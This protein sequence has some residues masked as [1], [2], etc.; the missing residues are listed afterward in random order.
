MIGPRY[1]LLCLTLTACG[2]GDA[3]ADGGAA[4]AYDLAGPQHPVGV[5]TLDLKDESREG[6][7]RLPT[8]VW[9]PTAAAGGSSEA[10]VEGAPISYRD[11]PPL[12]R[13]APYPVVIFSHGDR[14]VPNQ[15][16]FL[17]VA[18]A[19]RGYVVAAVTHTGNTTLNNSGRDAA[20]DN[21]PKDVS[22]ALTQLLE[23]AGEAAALRGLTD[24]A[25]VGLSGHSFGAWTTL[26][27]T[28]V[29][30]RFLS[31]LPISPGGSETPG[32]TKELG[33]PTMIVIGTEEAGDRYSSAKE[34][35]ERLGPPRYL[36]G[37]V[38]AG[39]GAFTDV[40]GVV[41][42]PELT[43]DGCSP[44]WRDPRDVQRVTNRLAAPFFDHYL[45]GT[46]GALESLDEATLQGE[47]LGLEMFREL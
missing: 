14:G 20:P 3:D 22:F 25:R 44:A 1:L 31:A 23:G 18:L 28:P 15:S 13:G 38:D 27:T 40:C 17:T 45:R 43:D 2:G 24:P 16:T 29:D 6:G 34:V 37:V 32:V 7:R 4:A 10:T 21:R 8:E 19:S 47:E 5:M 41:D 11:A 39:H 46:P 26:V 36:M 35:Y 33:I 42:T 12:Q 9:Y 30:D